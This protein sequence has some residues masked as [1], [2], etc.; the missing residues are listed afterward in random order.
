MRFENRDVGWCW[1]DGQV[2]P[3]NHHMEKEKRWGKW[4]VKNALKPIPKNDYLLRLRPLFYKKLVYSNVIFQASFP[5]KSVLLI[6]GLEVFWH[7][8]KNWQIKA[9][10]FCSSIYKVEPL[11]K[12][13]SVRCS[14]GLSMKCQQEKKIGYTLA[15]KW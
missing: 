1:D 10:K 9:A 13:V 2:F 11:H 5:K 14:W 12:A 7:F 8:W 4:F 15:Q 3:Q 6:T